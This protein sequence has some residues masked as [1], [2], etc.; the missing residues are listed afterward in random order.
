MAI[1]V[2]HSDHAIWGPCV[3]LEAEGE[4]EEI[5]E[6][7]AREAPGWSPLH[8]AIASPE[9]LDPWYRLGFAQM[10]VYGKRESGA[11]RLELPDVTIRRGGPADVETATRIDRVI[12]DAEATTP[13]FSSYELD[14][15]THRS[16]WEE[17][18]AGEKL[19][20][21]VAER[22]GEPVGHTTMHPDPH[23][24]GALHLGSTAVLP[25]AQ[26]RGIGLVLTTHALAHAREQG[27]PRMW[28]NWRTTNLQAS[29]YWPARG[30]E[31]A[32]IR[33][34]RRVPAL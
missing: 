23:D 28:T 30:F 26:G 10:H 6:E 24:E 19:A 32:R 22:D 1:T 29:R 31:V 33:L 21:F 25:E 4:P 2:Q 16:D 15:A 12:Y 5:R 9:G 17:T 11:E 20:Y 18:L 8:F 3:F 13:S 7:Y 14:G 27:Y 34:V